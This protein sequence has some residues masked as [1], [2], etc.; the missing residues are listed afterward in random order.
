[1]RNRATKES[2][3]AL[4]VIM[5]MIK[6]ILTPSNWKKTYYYLK[7][8]GVKSAVLAAM[9]RLEK[10]ENDAYH[11]ECPD[12]GELAKQRELSKDGDICFSILVPVYRTPNKYFL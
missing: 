2:L 1:M 5:S 9:E 10:S 4:V 6:K 7:K 8:N 3:V 11:Y 12:E